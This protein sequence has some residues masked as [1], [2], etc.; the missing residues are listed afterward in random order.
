[1]FLFVGWNRLA[2]SD[3]FCASC[4]EMAPAVASAARS[5]HSDVPCLACHTGTGLFGSLRY[6]PT[7]AREAITEFTPWNVAHGVLEARPCEDCH[8]N[9][10][11][12]PQQAAAHKEGANCAS[13]HGNVAHP[14]FRLAGFERPA[15][16]GSPSPSPTENP[17]PRLYVQT[18]GDDVVNDPGSCYNCHETDYCQTC[19]FRE[20]YPH[21][22]DWMSTHGQV[23]EERGADACVSCHPSTFCAGCH[24]TEI[25]H[26]STWLGEHW[27]SLQDSSTAPCMVCHPKTDCTDCHSR[28]AV[29]QEQDLYT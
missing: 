14:P 29:H 27:R 19:H 4:H 6:V 15:A 18:H 24:G 8:T 20:T 3:R 28:H 11:S 23:Q 16:Q 5:V 10:R 25:P 7:L 26:T 9:L 21:P 12:T 1:M 13:C 22:K 2:T 17:H